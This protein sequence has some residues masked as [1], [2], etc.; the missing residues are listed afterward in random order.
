MSTRTAVLREADE[1]PPR[2]VIRHGHPTRHVF[3]RDPMGAWLCD[4]DPHGWSW[5]NV[6]SYVNARGPVEVLRPADLAGVTR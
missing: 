5:P 4:C 1:P 6:V 3:R 2:T